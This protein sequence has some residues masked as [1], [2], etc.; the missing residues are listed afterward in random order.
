MRLGLAV[1]YEQDVAAGGFGHE[2]GRRL[3]VAEPARTGSPLLRAV[4]RGD[5][6]LVV[7]L[8]GFVVALR[9][10]LRAKLRRIPIVYRAITTGK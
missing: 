7:Y 1:A 3:L 5:G 2:R 6:L 9:S 4:R 8:D 10:F